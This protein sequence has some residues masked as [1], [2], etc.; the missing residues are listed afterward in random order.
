M[1]LKEYQLRALSE[2]KAYF[3][4]LA[5]WKQKAQQIPEAEID[6]P[7]KAWEKAGYDISEKIMIIESGMH[8]ITLRIWIL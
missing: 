4:F 6:F 7:T 1:E 3:E 5:D 8:F 2:V